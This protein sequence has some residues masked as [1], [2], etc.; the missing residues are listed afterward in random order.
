M[1]VATQQH[2]DSCPCLAGDQNIVR[3]DRS[4]RLGQKGA[5]LASMACVFLVEV[6]DFE[7]KG[8]D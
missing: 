3:T 6:D 2:E 4:A 5:D 1:D 8:M 7:A